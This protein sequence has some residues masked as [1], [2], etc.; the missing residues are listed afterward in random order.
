MHLSVE[1]ATKVSCWRQCPAHKISQYFLV[2]RLWKQHG[3]EACTETFSMSTPGKNEF[4]LN[5]NG[6]GLNLQHWP[7]TGSFSWILLLLDYSTDHWLDTSAGFYCCWITVLTTDWRLQLDS[8][9]AGLQYWPLT[10]HISWILLLLDYSTDHWLD[11][12]AGF[13]CCWT[14]V[15]TTDWRL[16]LDSTAAGHQHWP[17]T[18][19][20]NWILLPLDYSTDHWLEASA[21]TA[22]ET[23]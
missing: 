21:T 16:Q 19:S 18:G 4:H 8:T 22:S 10:G 1:I 15:L 14:T 7:L 23:V 17:L 5:S 12:S 9:A 20:S 13:Y 11:A 2:L 3:A 6:T